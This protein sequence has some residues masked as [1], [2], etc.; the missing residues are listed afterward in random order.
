M[1]AF[2]PAF[3][4][5]GTGAINTL[6]ALKYWQQYQFWKNGGSTSIENVHLCQFW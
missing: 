1:V 6:A 4:N 5:G 3:L 2:V